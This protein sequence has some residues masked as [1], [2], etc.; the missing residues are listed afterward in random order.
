MYASTKGMD[1]GRRNYRD[2]QPQFINKKH[3]HVLVF[4]KME[5]YESLP[6]RTLRSLEGYIEVIPAETR[7]RPVYKRI[8]QARP[9][10]R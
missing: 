5:E 6:R 2:F 8:G 7:F 9:G 4:M 1:V 10:Q 3:K